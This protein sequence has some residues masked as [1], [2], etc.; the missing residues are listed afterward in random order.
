[1]TIGDLSQTGLIIE[2]KV[3]CAIK[4]VVHR[5]SNDEDVL[6]KLSQ[7]NT[8][9]ASIISLEF[10]LPCDTDLR[11]QGS[12]SIRHWT[13]NLIPKLGRQRFKID[14]IIDVTIVRTNLGIWPVNQ[15]PEL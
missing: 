9:D 1:M 2:A 12:V 8:T 6:V 11:N 7:R 13:G 4:E 10:M 15:G 14:H 5:D 3:Y